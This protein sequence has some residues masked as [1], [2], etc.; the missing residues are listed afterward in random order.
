MGE[1]RRDCFSSP[2]LALTSV[3]KRGARE[4]KLPSLLF[5]EGGGL[6]SIVNIS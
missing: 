3:S 6:M 1:A 4:C 5:V 2:T